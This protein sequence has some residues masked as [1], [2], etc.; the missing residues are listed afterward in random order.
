MPVYYIVVMQLSRRR[1]A[2]VAALLL[3]LAP[4]QVEIGQEARMYA[5]LTLWV[6]GALVC[7]VNLLRREAMD[8]ARGFLAWLGR[9]PRRRVL[10]PQHRWSV[11]RRGSHA[12]GTGLAL[13]GAPRP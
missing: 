7:M 2:F 6:C 8:S 9:M 12:P 11:P 5:L 13:D 4:M 1:T 10:Y 3:A